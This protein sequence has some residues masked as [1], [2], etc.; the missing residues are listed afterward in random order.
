[1]NCDVP[2]SYYYF[3]IISPQIISLCVQCYSSSCIVYVVVFLRPII[4]RFSLHSQ[5][6][7]HF[8]GLFSGLGWYSMYLVH[9]VLVDISR[10]PKL[11]YNLLHYYFQINYCLIYSGNHESIF[12]LARQLISMVVLNAYSSGNDV[13]QPYFGQTMHL[14]NFLFLLGLTVDSYLSSLWVMEITS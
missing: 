1:M 7:H 12:F 5:V 3:Y 6:F 8:V 10:L 2:K 13:S 14:L 11:T 9:R 4:W